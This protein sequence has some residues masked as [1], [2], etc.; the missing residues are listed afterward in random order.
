M[1]TV[2]RTTAA[3]LILAACWAALVFFATSEGWLKQPIAPRGDSSRFLRAATAFVDS[4]NRG[5]A[6]LAILYNGAVAGVHA[7]SVGAA[8][9]T[10][11]VFQVASLSKW[12]T[13]WGVMS[14]VQEGKIDLDA[15]VSRYLRRWALPPGRFDN[16]AVT[17]RRLL[18]HTAGLTDGLGYAGFP[19]GTQVQTLEA[20]LALTSDASPGA[21]GRVEVGIKPGAEWQYSGGGYAILQLVIEEVSGE[22]F[23]DYMQRVIFRPLGMTHSTFNWTRDAGSSLAT[24]YDANSRP[25]THYRFSAVAPTS[26]YTSTADLTRFLFAHLPGK[27]GEPVGRGVLKPATVTSMAQPHASKFGE[28]I[29]GLGTMLY[30][31]NA[32]GGFVIGHDG[33]N[34]PATNTTARLNTATGNGIVILETGQP[35]L[36]T[37]LA[38]EWVF[39]ETGNVDFLAFT[40]AVPGMLRTIAF[41]FAAIVLGATAISLAMR[42]RRRSRSATIARA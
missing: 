21:S 6:V 22:P 3:T 38:G 2:V 19:D 9:D 28:R 41:G 42:R 32:S 25:S 24:M 27:N 20:S 23:E 35:L 33:S 7:T 1:R 31:G 30:A 13:A 14:L 5:N 37:H 12:V 17:V 29:W 11:S 36:A 10:S 39:W 18:S 8:V 16:N 34:A 15:P 40:L 4:A 26:L